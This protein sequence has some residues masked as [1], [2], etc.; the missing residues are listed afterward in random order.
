MEG[1]DIGS[2]VFP[3]SACKFYLDADP[4][5]R[6]RRRNE[7]IKVMEGKCDVAEVMSSLQRRDAMDSQRKTAPLQVADGAV[8]VN[9][10]GMGIDD[11]VADILSRIPAGDHVG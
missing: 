6:A 8:V 9:T 5:E 3:D 11:V 2:V 10:T 1:R 4:E 7:E